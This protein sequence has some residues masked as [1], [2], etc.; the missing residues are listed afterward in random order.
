MLATG[1]LVILT[2]V[3]AMIVVA[4]SYLP[5]LLPLALIASLILWF[6]A[7]L[8]IYKGWGLSQARTP[9]E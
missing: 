2:T 8:L 3:V 7:V 5:I 6:P 9:T 1:S 4:F